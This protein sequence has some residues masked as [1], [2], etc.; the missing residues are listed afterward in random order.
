MHGDAN[1]GKL[2]CKMP[3]LS[4]LRCAFTHHSAQEQVTIKP[5]ALFCVNFREP[6]ARQKQFDELI[7][8]KRQP[9][10]KIVLCVLRGLSFI[11]FKN[12][13]VFSQHSEKA[14]LFRFYIK[15][16]FQTGK[17]NLKWSKTKTSYQRQK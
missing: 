8:L 12:S 9:R 4:A 16:K 1:S 7:V 13:R 17:E 5:Q 11:E 14:R 10:R 6:I 3:L 2:L 15:V